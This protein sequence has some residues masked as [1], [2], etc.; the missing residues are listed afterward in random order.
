MIDRKPWLL[1]AAFVIS[2]ASGQ[3]SA[4][5]VRARRPPAG[6][7]IAFPGAEGFGRF[8]RGGRGGDV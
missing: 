3:A 7:Q 6:E 1:L 5:D 8:A 2:F 4:A